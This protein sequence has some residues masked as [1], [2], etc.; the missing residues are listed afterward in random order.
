M[1]APCLS[2]IIVGAET[3]FSNN[4]EM[5][6]TMGTAG[7]QK[8]SLFSYGAPPAATNSQLIFASDE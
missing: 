2:A 7:Y 5:D 4:V 8:H 6:W 1:Q 3:D